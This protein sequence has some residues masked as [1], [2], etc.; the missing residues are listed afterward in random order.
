PDPSEINEAIKLFFSE[1]AD[2]DYEPSYNDHT[3]FQYLSNSK[4]DITLLD[5]YHSEKIFDKYIIQIAGKDINA[6]QYPDP[7]NPKLP[8]LDK[9]KIFHKDLLSKILITY[10]NILYFDLKHFVTLNAFTLASSSNANKCSW[11]IVYNYTY[12]I[13]YRDLRDF[14]EKLL[15]LVKEDRVKRPAIFLVKKE[16]YKLEDYLVQPKLDASEIWSRTFSSE[17]SEKEEFQL[18]KDETT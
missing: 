14:V 11:H 18:I 12:Y 10:T 9:Y 8:S 13:D 17:K 7:T 3:Y 6:R 5:A 4:D 16:Y 15:E 1:L 2:L